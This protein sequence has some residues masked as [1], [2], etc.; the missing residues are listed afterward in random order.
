MTTSVRIFLIVLLFGLSARGEPARVSHTVADLPFY[1]EANKG[2]YEPAV[3]FVART[4]RGS[5][6]VMD[7]GFVLDVFGSTPIRARFLRSG[8]KVVVE[9]V[10]PLPARTHHF[11]G[12]DPSGWK[13]NLAVFHRV[14]VSHLHPGIHVEHY[15]GPNGFEHDYI[16]DPGADPGRIRFAIEG[17]NRIDLDANGDLVV[18]AGDNIVRFTKPVIYQQTGQ[19]RDLV[20]GRYVRGGPSEF[21]FHLENYDT[22][23][24][25]II[26]PV[27]SPPTVFGGSDSESLRD[28]DVDNAGNIYAVGSTRS[29]D[30]L[31]MNP[32]FPNNS[33]ETDVFIAKFDSDLNMIWATFLGGSEADSGLGLAVGAG[34]DVHFVG[35]TCSANFPSQNAMQQ[36]Y[37]GGCD[38]FVAQLNTDGDVLGFSTYLGGAGSDSARCVEIDSPG[39]LYICGETSSGEFPSTAGALSETLQGEA[40]CFVSKMPSSGQGMIY[41]TFVGGSGRESC[42]AMALTKNG[43]AVGASYS[44]DFPTT[45]DAF[46]GALNPKPSPVPGIDFA[47]AT[48]AVL[49]ADGSALD[50]GSYFGGAGDDF[51]SAV[52]ID[53]TG[54]VWLG[55]GTDSLDFPVTPD[56]DQAVPL[57]GGYS[58]WIASFDLFFPDDA[59]V[60]FMHQAARTSTSRRRPIRRKKSPWAV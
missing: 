49:N 46:Q 24:P 53:P 37:G 18:H 51:A 58:A 14:R 45:P 9:G 30:F 38:G 15:R 33:G 23:R 27:L 60:S 10:D 54:K 21:G 34:G 59:Y 50:Y 44:P 43:E 31:T 11:I 2:R 47:D 7:D 3:R 4:P 32:L 40:D 52:T 22:S 17:G 36:T 55:G 5:M 57:G 48:A 42:G 19:D 56:A 41:S 26:D 12:A 25:L 29:G 1:F 35:S 28:V 13:R 6:F 20:E 39:N 16:V 8:A